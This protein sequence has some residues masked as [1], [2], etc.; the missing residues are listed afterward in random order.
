MD[1][2]EGRKEEEINKG[3]G[4]KERYGGSKREKEK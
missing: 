4:K 2:R 1:E 3:R